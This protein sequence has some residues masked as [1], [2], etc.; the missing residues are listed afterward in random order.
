MIQSQPGFWFSLSFWSKWW[1]INQGAKRK[2]MPSK[3]VSSSVTSDKILPQGHK[4]W[5]RE[6]A[7][8]RDRE[9]CIDRYRERERERERER[10]R[11][12]E[13]EE[14]ERERERER[15]SSYNNQWF[16]CR[17]RSLWRNRLARSAVNRKVG[18]SSPPR[19]ELF[20]LLIPVHKQLKDVVCT[21]TCAE[22]FRAVQI[23]FLCQKEKHYFSRNTSFP[24]WRSLQ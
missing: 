22:F 20:I 4:T 19:D 3:D 1:T 18:G 11:E 12:K 17:S 9:I 10:G 23:L 2:Y 21:G 14:W 16:L 13:K 5:E 7:R 15:Y 24:S 6:K 8:E